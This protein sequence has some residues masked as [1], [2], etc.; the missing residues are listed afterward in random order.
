M[1]SK[2]QPIPGRGTLLNTA[3]VLAGALIGLAAGR[4]IPEVYR[5]IVMG[6]IGL[7]T[8]GIGVKMFLDS[9]NILVVVAS[10]VLGGVIGMALGLQSG[11]ETFS[12]W[13]ESVFGAGGSGTF[14]EAIITTSVLFCVGPLTLLGCMQDALEGKIELL[15]IK[16]TL[17]GFGAIFFAAALG[18]GVLV[19]AG[20]V[21]V[22]QGLVTLAATPLKRLIHDEKT[23]SE[24]TA[25]GGIMMMAIGLNLL[26]VQ[27][28]VFGTDKI[29]VANYLP[30]LFLAPAFASLVGRRAP[31][32]ILDEPGA[33]H[34]PAGPKSE[35]VSDAATRE[36]VSP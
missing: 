17:D 15:A 21:L 26:G 5:S 28:G 13:A 14:A 23:I 33:P 6:G 10:I 3:T 34:V 18:P 1:S 16:S 8:L 24:A 19:T 12:N 2:R 27:V 22:F 20:V 30:A 7:V 9:K 32:P 36:E 35:F 25:A 11:I 4:F 29:P 31:A